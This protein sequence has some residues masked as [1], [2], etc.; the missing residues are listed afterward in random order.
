MTRR[1]ASCCCGGLRLTCEGEPVRISVCHCPECQRRTGSAF[2]YQARFPDAAVTLEG[3]DAQWVRHVD[4]GDEVRFRFCPVCGSTV[5][6]QLTSA[7]GFTSVAV[8]AFADPR[9][10][11]PKVSVW[12]ETRH[13]WVALP[14]GIEDL[15]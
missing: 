3:R 1:I 8:G 6:W 15:D 5:L 9:L 12:G 4:D 11:A 10:P 14:A 13:S 7:P 2:G